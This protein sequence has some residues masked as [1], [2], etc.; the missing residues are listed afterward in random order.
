MGEIPSLIFLIEKMT[1]IEQIQKAMAG[2]VGWE[3]SFNPAEAIDNELTQTESGLYY[4]NAHPLLTLDNVKSI[5]PDAFEYQY[6]HWNAETAYK[7]G[8]KVKNT[9]KIWIA[10][11]DNV[12]E[13]PAVDSPFWHEY[14]YLSDYLRR[15]TNNGIATMVQRFVEI[16]GLQQETKNL[17]ERRTFFDGAG[18]INATIQSKGKLVG[19]EIEPVR[20]MG[21]TAKIEKIGL[22]MKGATGVV[23]MYLFHSSQVDPIKTFDL[24]FTL[25]NGGFQWFTLEDCYLPYIADTNNSGGCWFLCYN[26]NDLPAGMEAINVSKDWS[27]EPCG[28]CNIGSLETWRE[29]TK[30]LF[31]SPFCTKA[32]S[33]FAQYPELWDISQTNYTN[34][35]NYGL[36]C[37]ITI[38][39]DL[40]DFIIEQRQLF[41]SVLQKQVAAIALRTLAMNPDVRVNRNQSNASKMDILYEL[42][43]NTSGVRPGGLGYELKQAYQALS[44]NTQGID[45]I[46]L[47]CNNHGVKYTTV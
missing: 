12:A 25:T 7:I 26:Q 4:Q 38:G 9:G 22:Q 40:T 42:D 36:N 31:I 16:K 21:V 24:N 34:T 3:Q 6:P 39:C 45:R 17:L 33:T 46:C 44:L 13:T 41:A 28:T 35:I 37:E 1:R 14:N 29:L 30:Y 2:L 32:P 23:K 43:G 10:I 18:R 5:V 47:T 11:A 15:L 19:F 20:S 8:D 27:R